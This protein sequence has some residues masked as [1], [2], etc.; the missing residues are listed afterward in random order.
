MD[1]LYCHRPVKQGVVQSRVSW[2]SEMERDLFWSYGP[3]KGDIPINGNSSRGAGGPSV[4]AFYCEH[5]KKITI[6]LYKGE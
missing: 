5:C 1:C 2:F 6:Q 3:G 4:P